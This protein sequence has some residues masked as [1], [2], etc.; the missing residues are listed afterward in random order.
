M[1]FENKPK[2]GLGIYTPSEI[3]QILRLPNYKITRW[4]TKYWDGE[5]GKEFNSLYSWKTGNS[6]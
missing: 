5:L 3:A 1:N 6:V 4:I 2:I